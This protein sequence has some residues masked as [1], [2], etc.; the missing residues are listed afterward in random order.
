MGHV[1]SISSWHWSGRA[2]GGTVFVITMLLYTPAPWRSGT[3]SS[4]AGVLDSCGADFFSHIFQSPARSFIRGPDK[5]FKLL[6][7]Q[8]NDKFRTAN[9]WH[10]F[11]V[12]WIEHS[13]A[14]D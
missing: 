6:E 13:I 9:C 3:V 12:A 7:S 11:P 2:K 8:Y 14:S 10:L 4:K 1:G 5:L